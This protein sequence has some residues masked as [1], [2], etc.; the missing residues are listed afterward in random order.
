MMAAFTLSQAYRQPE[1]FYVRFRE[2]HFESGLAEV[3]YI[4]F[5]SAILWQPVLGNIH[6]A[7]NL[8]AA[9]QWI[10]IT[11]I[12]PGNKDHVAINAQVNNDGII[13]WL[14]VD[15]RGIFT[16]GFINNAFYQLN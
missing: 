8:E 15:V 3:I 16:D 13:R 14:D 10:Q 11:F 5:G 12:Q 7:D 9:D 6:A 1:V 4:D 2:C